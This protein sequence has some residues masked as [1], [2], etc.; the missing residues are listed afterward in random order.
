MLAPQSQ[1]IQ[2]T[3]PSTPA[4]RSPHW[5]WSV[6]KVKRKCPPRELI[7]KHVAV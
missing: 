7:S 5:R 6:K 3:S 4:S 2:T 1:A